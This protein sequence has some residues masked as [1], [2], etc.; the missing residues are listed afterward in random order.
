VV[1]EDFEKHLGETIGGVGGKAFGI[2][3]VTNRIEGP[4]DIRGAVNQIKTRTIGHNEIF[5]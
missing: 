3:E 5:L 4:K 2:G 1:F